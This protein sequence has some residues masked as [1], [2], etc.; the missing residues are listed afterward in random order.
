MGVM[1]TLT[2]F[3]ATH[4]IVAAAAQGFFGAVL[5]DIM[6]FRKWKSW[7]E[8]H[9]WDPRLA[10]L[11]YVQGAVGSLLGAFGIAATATAAG[12]VALWL[13]Q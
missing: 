8:F 9:T 11:R 3:M 10:L 2:A 1:Q 13:L 4:P 5:I 7:D 12:A 6:A